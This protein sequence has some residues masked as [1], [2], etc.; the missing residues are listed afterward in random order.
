MVIILFLLLLIVGCPCVFVYAVVTNDRRRRQID[1]V[2]ANETYK[3]KEEMRARAAIPEP[4]EE[5]YASPHQFSGTDHQ[6]GVPGA[7]TG[8][9]TVREYQA[10]TRHTFRCEN[11][12]LE[13]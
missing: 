6:L 13:R 9:C 5:P 11:S 7:A 3:A 10:T 4:P 12:D 1:T 8:K 2:L